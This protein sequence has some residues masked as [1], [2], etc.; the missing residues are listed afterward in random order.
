MKG[1]VYIAE[2]SAT[3]GR[4]K[5]GYTNRPDPED[6]LEELSKDT[7]AADYLSLCYAAAFENPS[8]AETEVH[9]ILEGFRVKGEWFEI[10]LEF[11][12]EAIELC[13]YEILEEINQHNPGQEKYK[14]TDIPKSHLPNKPTVTRSPFA[15]LSDPFIR[16]VD[17]YAARRKQRLTK[18]AEL[19]LDYD[20]RK[21][22]AVSGQTPVRTKSKH[23]QVRAWEELVACPFCRSDLVVQIVYRGNAICTVCYKRIEIVD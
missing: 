14:P 2:Q 23:E 6:R 19:Q 3:P 10:D 21:R 11:A 20:V 8:E 16:V 22:R 1:W 4:L 5:I 18:R 15:L 12:I 7:G 13:G 17:F 9:E